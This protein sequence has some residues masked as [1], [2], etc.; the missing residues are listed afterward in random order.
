MSYKMIRH[1]TETVWNNY[2]LVI[3]D[4]FCEAM[5]K[6][7]TSWGYFI[8]TKMTPEYVKWVMTDGT[9]YSTWVTL[10]E[11][12]RKFVNHIDDYIS[13]CLWD[14]DVWTVD[15]EVDYVKD[16]FEEINS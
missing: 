3:D 11:A 8:F 2:E 12:E 14:S 15:S 5:T 16:E 6:D 4:A 1:T 9:S 13:S 7:F 10:S